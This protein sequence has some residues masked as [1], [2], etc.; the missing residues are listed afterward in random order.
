M[1]LEIGTL[2]NFANFKG[3]HMCWSLFFNQVVGKPATLLKKRL[4]HRFFPANFANVLR[5]A[6]FVEHMRIKKV[7]PDVAVIR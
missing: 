3:K 6:Y 4:Q 2:E 5:A 1:L 7:P